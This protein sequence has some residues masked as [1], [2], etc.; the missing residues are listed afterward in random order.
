MAKIQ[1][2]VLALALASG[3]A[4]AGDTASRD[5]EEADHQFFAGH[6]SEAETLYRA[7]AP[8]STDYKSALRQLGTIALYENRLD[9]AE[10]ELR[11]A[12]AGPDHDTKIYALLAEI[13]SR[14]GRFADARG[15]LEMAGKPDRAAAYGEYSKTK[16]PYRIVSAA[17]RGRIPFVQTDPLPAVE[18][19]VNGRKGLF[20]ID[21]GG[22]EIVL[23]PAFASAAGVAAVGKGNGIFAGGRTAGI[24]F[25]RIAK[26]SLSPLVVADVPAMLLSTVGFS[27]AAGGKP[28]AGVIGT[29]FLSRFMATLDYPHGALVLEP[30]DAAAPQGGIAIPFWLV[31]DHFIVAHGTLDGGAEQLFLVDS[32]LAGFAFT[33]P[34]ST[35]QAA[36][37][38]LPPPPTAPSGAPVGQSTAMPF[39]IRAL[40]LGDLKAENLNGLN[41]P[42]PPSLETSLG[43][44]IG[45]IVSHAFLRPYAVTFDFVGMK[46][47]ARKTQT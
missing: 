40:T 29:Q 37:L 6:F 39:A 44:H 5:I 17:K 42:F 7:V 41:G 31:R 45:G 34:V 30:R 19:L 27:G 33:A 25:G 20:L 12:L 23:D 32:G 4:I 26:F 14:R 35:L 18:A 24:S 21:T 22:A 10:R 11:S 8:T 9:D 15:W 3:A 28:V 13:A 43:V 38:G 47:I 1:A 46:I 2:I 36:G 16:P